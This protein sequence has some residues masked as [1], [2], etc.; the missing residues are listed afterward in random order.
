VLVD[1]EERAVLA[2]FGLSQIHR[3]VDSQNGKV[4]G[5]LPWIA[6]ERIE[7]KPL[8][9]AVDVYAFAVTCYELFSG[10]FP[11]VA[12]YRD[13]ADCAGTRAWTRTRSAGSSPSSSSARLAPPN[14][15]SATS[16]A[17]TTRRGGS[18]RPAGR[19]HPRSARRRRR[20]PSSSARSAGSSSAVASVPSRPCRSSRRR[21]R[22]PA[23]GRSSSSPA[24]LPRPHRRRR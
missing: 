3:D 10:T 14:P 17:S 20:P 5:A 12:Q 9:A 11:C 16:S 7:R 23:R 8:S 1:S 18:S 4:F 6:P 13:H 15:R 21:A 22:W 2:D 19:T 24:R